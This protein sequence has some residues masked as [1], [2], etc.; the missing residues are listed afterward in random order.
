M[1]TSLRVVPDTNVVI[2]AQNSSSTSPN[3]EFF[4]RW[5][6]EEFALLFSKDTLREYIKKLTERQVP[7]ERIKQLIISIKRIG[8]HTSILFFHLANYPS[9]PDDIPFIL[10]AENGNASH[11]IS[12]DRHLLELQGF[13]SFK[14]CKPLDFLFE[15]RKISADLPA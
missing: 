5:Q 1:K 10:C 13:Y 15:L 9:D 12:Y 11:L 3:K 14:I 2:A 4:T 6:N 7:R 8:D